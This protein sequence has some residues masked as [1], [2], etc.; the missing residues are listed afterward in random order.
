MNIIKA[1]NAVGNKFLYRPDKYLV[2]DHWSVMVEKEGILTGDCDDFALT[3]IWYSCDKNL[4]KFIFWA[5]LLHKYKF[6]YAKTKN[7][8]GHLVG[9]YNSLF[10]DNWTKQPLPKEQ[11]LAKTGHNLKFFFPSPLILIQLL[12]GSITRYFK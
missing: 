8:E 10:F 5:L 4:L 3:S 1:V 6:W 7:G 12:M 11:F 2:F 9:S